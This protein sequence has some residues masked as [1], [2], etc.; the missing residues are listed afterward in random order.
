MTMPYRSLNLT[1]LIDSYESRSMLDVKKSMRNK[2]EIDCNLT[3][4]NEIR[5][6]V[7]NEVRREQADVVVVKLVALFQVWNCE[8]CNL[9]GDLTNYEK[10]IQ[11][12]IHIHLNK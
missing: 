8:L 6:I 10:G 2:L 1:S 3:C 7:W 5:V 11:F 9:W 12:I 4:A